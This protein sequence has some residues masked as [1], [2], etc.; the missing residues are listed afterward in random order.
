MIPENFHENIVPE[1]LHH[2][3]ERFIKY[4]VH[5]LSRS[6]DRRT[7]NAKQPENIMSAAPNRGIIVQKMF[8]F[9]NVA[10]TVMQFKKGKNTLHW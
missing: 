1:N 10:A 2:Y 7:C 9:K 6:T 8:R 4:C 3:P 5:K